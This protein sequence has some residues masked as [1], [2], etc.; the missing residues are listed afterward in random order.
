MLR[1]LSTIVALA[2]LSAAAESSCEQLPRL[3]RALARVHA[4]LTRRAWE[5]NVT[6]HDNPTGDE[7]GFTVQHA[8]M[9]SS[10]S[11]SSPSCNGLMY[12][13]HRV[14]DSVTACSSAPTLL[15]CLSSLPSAVPADDARV[16][17][18]VSPAFP[19]RYYSDQG[20]MLN[21]PD[22]GY[23]TPVSDPGN[24]TGIAA[25]VNE[26][27]VLQ[28]MGVLSSLIPTWQQLGLNALIWESSSVEDYLNYDL[29]PGPQRVY[30]LNDLHR[31][32]T[33]TFSRLLSNFTATLHAEGLR[34]YTM[35]FDLTYPPRLA[36]LYNLTSVY[37]PDLPLVLHAKFTELFANI[38]G[39][40][41]VL[42]YVCDSWSPRAGYD[43][44]IIWNGPVEM[45]YLAT[46]YYNAITAA[47]NGSVEVIFSM[48]IPVSPL[49]TW[50]IFVNNTPANIT[51]LINDGQGDFLWDHD[52]NDILAEGGGRQRRIVMVCD[53]FR[54]YDG[55]GRT[56]S[57]PTE[58]WAQ[59]VRVAANTSIAGIALSA[60]WSPGNS[61]PDSGAYPAGQLLNWTASDGYKSWLGAWDDF[62]IYQLKD[63]GLLSPME[64]NAY[65]LSNLA[66]DASADPVALLTTW[67]QQ[68][69]LYMSPDAAAYVAAA[70][71]VSGD[72]WMAKYL[73][74]VDEYAQEW[75]GVFTP[76]YAANPES[77]GSG[78][79]SLY[80]NATL[81]Q[82]LAANARIA[83]SFSSALS[84]VQT[85]LLINGTSLT[86]RP[87]KLSNAGV[88]ALRDVGA[89]L[90]LAVQKT[91]DYI[92]LFAEFRITAWLNASI[93]NTSEPATRHALC[94]EM[95][96]H[97]DELQASVP[98]FHLLY[99]RE[100]SAWNIGAADP[101]LDVRPYFFRLTQRSMA[102]WI[103]M[104]RADYTAA[105][106]Q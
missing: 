63:A 34:A 29:L 76:K 83:S 65:V 102:D 94:A 24:G 12:G 80:A 57:A 6:L 37:S 45:A 46:L 31:N 13:L 77:A 91:G 2:A 96:P 15:S 5:A 98:A 70:F 106:T 40:D 48:W 7:E 95:A 53:V 42:L 27:R 56:M 101:V 79:L 20:Q 75:S 58:L 55:W 25:V 86:S 18:S 19:R 1:A 21:M 41:G 54:Q 35:L 104:L 8:A 22:R 47:S 33:A 9:S 99:P 43:F 36:Q 30:E 59:R 82:I 10:L 62:R 100:S 69:P 66:W 85:A 39:L 74:G 89:A 23:F 49:D 60:E 14:A 4:A 73:P 90:E 84:L 81:P 93:G 78:M 50:G 72:G 32:R 17:F 52:M 103:L 51:L 38:P 105:C 92:H 68:A 97:L 88:A 28:D 26:S 11:I 87:A 71:N 64:A 16:S 44:S 61:W 67:A 3:Q